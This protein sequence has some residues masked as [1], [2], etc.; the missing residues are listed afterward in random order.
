MESNILG[1]NRDKEETT[2]IN[3]IS[4]IQVETGWLLDDGQMVTGMETYVLPYVSDESK[5][6]FFTPAVASTIRAINPQVPN[7]LHGVNKLKFVSKTLL[8]PVHTFNHWVLLKVELE[9]PV[10]RSQLYDSLGESSIYCK[11]SVSQL[12]AGI[13]VLLQNT[14]FSDD[15]EKWRSPKVEPVRSYP[16]AFLQQNALDC[17]MFTFEWIRYLMIGTPV[18]SNQS[19]IIATRNLLAKASSSSTPPPS[20]FFLS[21]SI[22]DGSVC[23]S[24][25]HRELLRR[26]VHA[27]WDVNTKDT[28]QHI[29]HC[30]VFIAIITPSYLT[31]SRTLAELTKAQQHSSVKILP[32]FIDV[33]PDRSDVL[34]TLGK[35]MLVTFRTFQDKLQE[36]TSS[37]MKEAGHLFPCRF[38]GRMKRSNSAKKNPIQFFRKRHMSIP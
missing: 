28:A 31:T 32:L 38:A 37:M 23:A 8:F 29:E 10:I 19:G 21:F 35:G 7:E 9:P 6:S 34:K 30:Q 13:V 25:L 2:L 18:S 24:L 4:D 16:L 17:G 20:D 14:S 5:I 12:L 11:N 1:N 3:N 26:G 33:E 22:R 15:H 27:F 36:F